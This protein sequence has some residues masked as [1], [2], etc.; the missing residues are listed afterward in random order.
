M[1]NMETQLNKT[2]S[3]IKIILLIV[4]IILII[5]GIICINKAFDLKDNYYMSSS[6]SNLNRHVYVGGDAYNYIINANYF[7]G[8]ITLGSMFFI[9]SAISIATN[10]LLKS[11]SERN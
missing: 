5:L 4:A 3:K 6:Y 9:C 10:L 7:T 2:K 11:S 1:E 8:Y